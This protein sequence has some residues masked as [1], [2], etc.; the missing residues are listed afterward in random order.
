MGWHGIEPIIITD[1]YALHS[2]SIGGGSR[3]GRGEC[4]FGTAG[5]TVESLLGTGMTGAVAPLFDAEVVDE[6][7][8]SGAFAGG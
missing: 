6:C 2:H 1:D 8:G 4:V 5:F 3:G 7:H